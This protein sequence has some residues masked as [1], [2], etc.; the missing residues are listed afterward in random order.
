M[1]NNT[2]KGSRRQAK[3]RVMVI[4]MHSYSPWAWRDFFFSG[5]SI[6]REEPVGGVDEEEDREEVQHVKVNEK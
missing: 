3:K 2:K 4:L 6:G 5:A 1:K